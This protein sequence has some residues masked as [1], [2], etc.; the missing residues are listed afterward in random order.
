MVAFSTELVCMK[1]FMSLKL[2]K[3][4]IMLK[5][6]LFEI[7]GQIHHDK[8]VVKEKL[9]KDKLLIGS[10]FSMKYLVF[11]SAYTKS[12]RTIQKKAP[13]TASNSTIFK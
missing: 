2:I 10:P 5:P 6:Y 12:T 4:R 7:L 13:F 8:L 9:L 1:S 3:L 11:H